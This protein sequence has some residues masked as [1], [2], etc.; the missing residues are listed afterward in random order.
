MTTETFKLSQPL[1][2]H[3]GDVIEL[4][5]KAPRARAFVAYNDPF[6]L[7]PRT[8]G[9]GETEGLEFVFN[10][11]AMM[12]FLSDMTG[13]DDLI[14]GDMSGGDFYRLRGKAANM[15]LEMVPDKNP[16]EQSVA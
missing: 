5:L 1:K 13:L 7:K 10:N 12:Q 11:K 16:S 3:N 9:A 8:N 14:L 2:T 6:Q 15:I 4:T